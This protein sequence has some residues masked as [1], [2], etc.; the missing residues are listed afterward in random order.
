LGRASRSSSDGKN[1]TQITTKA[2]WSERIGSGV[3]VY[4][5]KMWVF[6]GR[7]LNDLWSSSNGKDWKQECSAPWSTRSANYSVVFRD[8]VW[9]FSGKTG[10]DDSWD[11]AIWV[12]GRK[13]H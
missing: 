9:L 8:H 5:G 3:V 2:A 7:E 10:R 6:G 4:D 12:M 13:T 1:W 11:G